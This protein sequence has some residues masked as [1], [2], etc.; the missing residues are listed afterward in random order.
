MNMIEKWVFILITMGFIFL[1]T[2]IIVISVSAEP[3]INMEVIKQ[4]ESSGDS[5]AYNTRSGAR[6]LYQIMP[7]CL[8]EY[9]NY[10]RHKYNIDQLFDCN[11]NYIIA[12]WYL[13]V[14]IPQMLNHYHKPLTKRNVLIS[15]NAGVSYVRDGK[16]SDKK[17]PSQTVEYIRKYN[18]GVE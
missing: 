5:L 14:R 13:N 16:T 12:D 18:K 2:Y 3:V 4:I 7:I 9:N 6:G 8:T 11:V 10:H 1:S 15:Y 17:L